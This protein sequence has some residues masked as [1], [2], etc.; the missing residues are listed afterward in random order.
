GLADSYVPR[1]AALAQDGLASP[2]PSPQILLALTTII[3][4]LNSDTSLTLH[5]IQQS[6]SFMPQYQIGHAHAAL[7][8]LFTAS[9]A[10][11]LTALAHIAALI[12]ED[13]IRLR[14]APLFHSLAA[15]C[16][17]SPTVR[18]FAS[19][20]VKNVFMVKQPHLPALS[21]LDC[22]FAFNQLRRAPK[23]AG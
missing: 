1:I 20:I 10:I 19:S 15:L 14:G 6:L 21:F 11:R 9:P 22:I 3:Q 8:S 23:A 12:Q 13:H 18:D 17:P 2:L 7:A 5:S 4:T 16:D